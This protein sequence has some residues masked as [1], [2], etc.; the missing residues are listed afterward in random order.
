MLRPCPGCGNVTC[1]AWGDECWLNNGC[2]STPPEPKV[3]PE[4]PPENG[5]ESIE[6]S[7]LGIVPPGHRAVTCPLCRAP[8][9]ERQLSATGGTVAVIECPCVPR[10]TMLDAAI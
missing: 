2:P 9:I 5:Y 10:V 8:A 1:P 6:R 7:G 4:R 3:A